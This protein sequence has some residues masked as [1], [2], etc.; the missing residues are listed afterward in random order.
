[1]PPMPSIRRRLHEPLLLLRL[2][3]MRLLELAPSLGQLAL[4]VVLLRLDN[5]KNEESVTESNMNQ[6]LVNKGD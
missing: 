6:W 3:H 2:R 1:M 5:E 4:E